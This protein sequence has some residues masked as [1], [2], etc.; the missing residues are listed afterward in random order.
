ME[1]KI[2]IREN[3]S[4]NNNTRIIL[5][6]VAV[7]VLV[8]GALVLLSNRSNSTQATK[9]AANQ[10]TKTTAP[11]PPTSAPVNTGTGI[12]G[13]NNPKPTETPTT[14]TPDTE[15][16]ATPAAGTFSPPSDSSK[17]NVYYLKGSTLTPVLRDKPATNIE[18]FL[19]NQVLVG[20]TAA[21]KTAGTTIDW[22]FGK[23]SNCGSGKSYKFTLTGK[24]MKIDLCREFTGAS[25][26]NFV[27]AMTQSLTETGRVSKV[28]IINTIGGCL[29][30]AVGD[31]S[32]LK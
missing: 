28:A 1:D 5:A 10:N 15:E 2:F 26:S 32:C 6:I 11:T 14:I 8:G 25:A 18:S 20:P 3:Q 9:P 22:T 12:I 19:I 16:L 31:M 17:L 30:A 24:S 21:E 7:V 23:D 13:S 4:G 27:N 29:G